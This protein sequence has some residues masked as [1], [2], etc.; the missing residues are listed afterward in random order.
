M[1][2]A[3]G[4]RNPGSTNT[5]DNGT[6]KMIYVINI[7]KLVA[8]AEDGAVD[9]SID[10]GRELGQGHGDEADCPTLAG[11]ITVDDNTTG[12]PHWAALD[13]FN[14]TPAGSPTRMMFCDY[15]VAR[16]GY[17]GNHRC[18]MLNVDPDPERSATT[19]RSGTRTA[20]PSASTSTG[21]TGRATR[22]AGSTSRTRWCSSPPRRSPAEQSF[23]DFP[24]TARVAQPHSKYE[25]DSRTVTATISGTRPRRYAVAV[26]AFLVLFLLP[27]VWAAQPAWGHPYLV[28]TEPGPGVALPNTPARIQIG[29]TE[30]VVLEGSVPPSRRQRGP[31]GGR[32]AARGAEGR[33]RTGRR[34]QNPARRRRL[35]RP[36]GRALGGRAQLLG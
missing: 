19:R 21:P 9:C 26:S 16:T 28:Q 27:V 12:G 30:R 10:S 8:S 17:D 34:R 4:G 33:P 36:L 6:P 2:R 29:F 20:A 3:V 32:R 18:Y 11:V 13:N 1:F 25:G 24:F 7:E 23:S 14:F 5:Y 31:A 22:T 35:P 15:F